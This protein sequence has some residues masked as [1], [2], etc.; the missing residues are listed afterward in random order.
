MDTE[1]IKLKR[2]EIINRFGD[3]TAYNMHLK[4]DIYT[5]DPDNPNFQ[6]Q[7]KGNGVHLRRIVQIASDITNQ[8]LQSLRVL[9]L[10]CL[11]GM[12]GLEFARHGAEVVCIEGREPNIE[13]ARFAQD[14][15]DLKNI[16]FVQDDVRNLS[17]SKYGH[18]DVVLCLGILYHLDAP[19]VFSFV[20]SISEVCRRVAIIDTHFGISANRSYNHKGLEYQGWSYPEHPPEASK[21]ERLKWL[22][23]SLD[24][25]KS[26]WFTRPSL[27]NLLAR[28]G[29]SSVYACQNP[30]V[31]G[32]WADRDTLA[33]VKGTEQDLFSTPNFD[34]SP[35]AVWPEVSPVGP[36]PTQLAYLNSLVKEPQSEKD[37]IGFN[38]SQATQSE[39]KP[40]GLLK[41]LR[42]LAKRILGR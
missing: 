27:F 23:A 7:L 16:S 12:Y 18:F 20:E 28:S 39:H 25:E 9:D 19:D 3:W 13:K 40:Q 38:T 37:Q 22:W 6:A 8:P 24:N 26:F 17:V 32:S 29:F 2:Q 34:N 1:Q 15:L 14:I 36:H 42:R 31:P 10:A 11:E 41:R 5:Y 35:H 4:D 30:A 33:A 21:E